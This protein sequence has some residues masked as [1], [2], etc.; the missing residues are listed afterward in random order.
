MR[1]RLGLA[2]VSP[3]HIKA[4]PL[5]RDLKWVGRL[6]VLI[7]L[8]G[9]YWQAGVLLTR[10]MLS[11]TEA[12][13]DYAMA[14]LV[15]SGLIALFRSLIIL[16]LNVSWSL[17]TQITPCT[18]KLCHLPEC[19]A[20]KKEQELPT[21]EL[22]IVIFGYNIVIIPI[23]V[24]NELAGG[25]VAGHIIWGPYESFVWM[26]MSLWTLHVAW[27]ST[28]NYAFYTEG[29]WKLI[30][31]PEEKP[32]DNTQ[33]PSDQQQV[34][35]VPLP[36]SSNA[37]DD[38]DDASIATKEKPASDT[39]PPSDQ[40]PAGILPASASS[41][42]DEDDDTS[43][44]AIIFSTVL[45]ILVTGFGL[46]AIAWTCC[47][48]AIQLF[49]LLAPCASLYYRIASEMAAWKGADPTKPC[50]QLWKDGLEDELWWF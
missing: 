36:V 17:D 22:R 26:L 25:F 39:R 20:L 6:L 11:D 42:A 28:I 27:R 13:V 49:W 47:C 45:F 5:D 21:Q 16:L 4:V 34:G 44:S 43:I 50:P 24:L 30:A 8:S 1:P 14:F 2:I 29:L 12:G 37:D 35:T 10:R 38:D 18:E 19:I 46:A 7:I 23:T 48:V 33:T 15:L 31:D 3:E 41:N 40:E 9:Q 32:T